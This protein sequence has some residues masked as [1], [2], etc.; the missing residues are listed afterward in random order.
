MRVNIGNTSNSGNK[1]DENSLSD[2]N[3]EVG[4]LNYRII[5]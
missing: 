2:F 5:S 1:S 4:K 3:P